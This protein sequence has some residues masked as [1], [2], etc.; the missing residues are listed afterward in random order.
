MSI[1]RSAG[2]AIALSALAVPATCL[3]DTPTGFYIGVDGGL[4]DAIDPCQGV[5]TGYSCNH[6]DRAI[7]GTFGY[8]IIKY[9]GAEVSYA[10]FGRFDIT[11]PFGAAKFEITGFQVSG[12]GTL[13]LTQ[14]LAL[15]GRIGAARTEV[16][17]TINGIGP[18]VTGTSYTEAIGGSLSYNITNALTVRLSVDYYGKVGDNHNVG[19]TKLFAYTGGLRFSF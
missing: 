12:T 18:S 14:S 17:R 15:V 5:P 1:S 13:P 7:R 2:L 19:E 4:G 8:Q 6:T 11:G 16:K 9:A 3:A 10:D